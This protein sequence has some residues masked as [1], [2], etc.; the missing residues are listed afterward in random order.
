MLIKRPTDIPSSEITSKE[1]Y[2]NR[3]YFMQATA[4]LALAPFIGNAL[5]GYG[6][7]ALNFSKNKA[8]SASDELTPYKDV[9]H[10]NNYYEFATD[11]YSPAEMAQTLT[12][13]PW[14]VVIAGLHSV[15]GSA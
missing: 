12:T 13:D 6:N 7:P 15:R 2:L 9:T 11:K 4:G 8:L 5:A 3:R 1:V 10:Y 14:S